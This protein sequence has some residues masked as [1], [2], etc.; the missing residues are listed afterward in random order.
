[1]SVYQRPGVYVE[2]T[3]NPNAPVLGADTLTVAAFAGT[4]D[5]GPVVPT[6]VTSWSQYV[7]LFGGFNSTANNDLPLALYT[8]FGNGGS[9]AYVLRV[10]GS[11]AGNASIVFN[12]TTEDENPTLTVTAKT[13]GAWGTDIAIGISPVTD[14]NLDPGNPN[15]LY[16][17]TV[18]YKG[19]TAAFSVERFSG[20]SS[21]ATNPRFVETVINSASN[22]ITVTDAGS[23]EYP[24]DTGST[25]ANLTG[26]SLD[27]AAVTSSTIATAISGG[28]F[29]T[30]TNSLVLNAC[31]VTASGDVNNVISYAASREDV[32][33]LID[34]SEDTPEDQID[35]TGLYTN[36]S[37]AASY[38]PKIVIPNPQSTVKGATLT[39]SPSGALAGLYAATDTARGVF[40]APA[41]VLARLAG[42]VSV[43]KLT[44][45]QLD[46]MNTA[47]KPVNAIRYIPGSGIVVMGAR[48]LKAGYSDKY[49][50]VR[51]TLIYLRK[52]LTDLTE[53]AVFE[54][55]DQRLW[56]RLEDITSKFL[57]SFWQEG[58]LKGAT[59]ADAFFVKCD[60]ENNTTTSIDAG[61][62]NIEIGVALQRPAE[63]VI[64]KIGQ[65]E[66]G[67]TVTVA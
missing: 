7:T 29:D 4:S 36:S 43:Q 22:Y 15:N 24:A 52:A 1:M 33:V 61:E 30:V 48:T 46:A 2:E 53:F 67:T 23:G 12:D 9:S 6:L 18:Y 34:P 66:G 55:N 14:V 21:V 62:V 47:A 26:A 40:K 58:G 45:A 63:Y 50:P 56:A 32:F 19:A 41:G 5:R 16:D 57:T 31:G 28:A 49:I 38:Y 42:V 44:N 54:P 25:P 11:G 39:I 3:L 10:V 51:R 64:I 35:T 27:G 60:S 65:Y 59:S 17:V 8:F 37:L 13:P 20:V